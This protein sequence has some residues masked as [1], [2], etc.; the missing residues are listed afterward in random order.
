[1]VVT[2]RKTLIT[3]IVMWIM[4]NTAVASAITIENGILGQSDLKIDNYQNTLS[5]DLVAHWNFNEGS[6]SI[7]HDTSG[8]NNNGTING[9]AWTNGIEGSALRFDGIDDYVEIPHSP[10][11]SFT[12]VISIVLWLKMNSGYGGGHVISK[13]ASGGAT[14]ILVSISLVGSEYYAA[15]GIA[16]SNDI[17]LQ[18][19]KQLYPDIWYHI[20]G[21][22]DGTNMNLYVNGTLDDKIAQS[23]NIVPNSDPIDIGKKTHWPDMKFNGSIDEVR[24]YNRALSAS[25]IK[26]QYYY[27]AMQKGSAWLV[28]MQQAEG[29]LGGQDYSATIPSDG[30]TT[31]AVFAWI[32]T[33]YPT[34][35]AS[36]QKALYWIATQKNSNGSYN[37]VETGKFEMYTTVLG[38]FTSSMN[39][40]NMD[41]SRNWIL[42]RAQPDGS[43]AQ[44]SYND[45]SSDTYWAMMGLIL[46]GTDPTSQVIIKA[47]NYF[48]NSQRS[49][50]SWYDRG[51]WGAGP[52]TARVMY[53]LT[54]AGMPISQTNMSKALN[55]VWSQQRSDGGWGPVSPSHPGDVGDV[56][57][58]LIGVGID[59]NDPNI[60]KA[61][62]YLLAKQNADG[63]WPDPWA[64]SHAQCQSVDPIIALGIVSGQI[65]PFG[66]VMKYF[67]NNLSVSTDKPTYRQGETVNLTTVYKRN[68]ATDGALFNSSTVTGSDGIFETPQWAVG[69]CEPGNHVYSMFYFKPTSSAMVNELDLNII[70]TY[71]NGWP[72]NDP[73]FHN[74]VIKFGTI[75]NNTSTTLSTILLNQTFNWGGNTGWKNNSFTKAVQVD[76]NSWYAFY[77]LY[78]NNG[79]GNP[80]DVT[81]GSAGWDTYNIANDTNYNGTTVYSRV[82]W[83]ENLQPSTARWHDT[84]FQFR[85]LGNISEV[86]NVTLSVK[87]PDSF[88]LFTTTVT[89]DANGNASHSFALPFDAPVGV[90]TV[91]ANTTDANASTTFN[92]VD[93]IPPTVIATAPVNGDSNI[94]ITSKV[95][96]F[97]SEGM[98][99]S[100]AESAFF[101][102]GVQCT[103][104]WNSNTTLICVP[105]IPLLYA[106][107]YTITITT[108]AK[109]LAANAMLSLY[110][111]SFSTGPDNVPPYLVSTSPID[112]SKNVSVGTRINI[113]FS[114]MMNWSSVDAS[115]SITPDISR[116]FS[117]SGNNATI[118]PIPRLLSETNYVVTISTLAKDS[119]GNSIQAQYKFIFKTSRT[120]A[121]ITVTPG[122][123]AL[124]AGNQT[125]FEAH[126]FDPYWNPVSTNVSWAVNGGGTISSTGLFNAQ[127]V[128]DWKVYA[129]DSENRPLDV[130]ITFRYNWQHGEGYNWY[131]L[132]GCARGDLQMG[133]NGAG[134][135]SV[136]RPDNASK[137]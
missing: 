88:I 59:R 91:L 23:G 125:S 99:K 62:N 41:D 132:C 27:P 118:T 95:Y 11:L 7:A 48:L 18:G 9:P 137:P 43:F 85:V 112:E 52:A 93:E 122:F 6:G 111:F 65:A 29:F 60:T 47:R 76:V 21:V 3:T 26:A 130:V 12:N 67:T 73:G 96:I 135:Q 121:N 25:E 22:Y 98:N 100:S 90:Y 78:D 39:G 58:H 103:F 87:K 64:S 40:V 5:Q 80:D 51:S 24:I 56:I 4:M 33:D 115:I 55:Y 46:T 32:A 17:I 63:S 70:E 84:H 35:N 124:E 116:T 82:Y 72:L 77:L 10:S 71:Y 57:E 136:H 129:N 44:G 94:N 126:G 42:S 61:V 134:T 2:L 14:Q 69:D 66:K 50:G 31:K 131:G 34:S 53:A 120:L 92:V 104:Y 108:A 86:A 19:T 117:Y 8:N 28:T 79:D 102:P 119:A 97:F 20:A 133:R 83:A 128:G 36:I 49:D 107:I 101:S 37:S 38:M 110:T 114:E 16:A 74:V 127:K 13:C 89:T 45:K 81:G 105:Q 75:E 1:M 109:D 30:V 123:V 113:T 54:L 68:G 106:M 15:F